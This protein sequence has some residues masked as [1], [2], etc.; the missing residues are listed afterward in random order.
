MTEAFHYYLRVR[1]G[2]CDAQ[3]VV[4]NARYGDYVDL[5]ITEFLR[6]LGYGDQ[7]Q[8]AELDFQLVR[9]V[10]EWRAPAH[11]DDVLEATVE[12]QRVGN[13]SFALSCEFRVAGQALVLCS[14][15]TVYVLVDHATLS[16][17]AVPPDMRERLQRGAPGVRVDHAG[18]LPRA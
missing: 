4:F 11:Y 18:H 1:Y 9:Q 2:E 16:K 5:A 15:E 17:K 13:T 14:A 8:S 12:T 6:A 7:M 10:K 3:K